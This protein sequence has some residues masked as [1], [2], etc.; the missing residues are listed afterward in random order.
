MKCFPA[1]LTLR[2]CPLFSAK[3]PTIIPEA[4]EKDKGGA[5]AEEPVFPDNKILLSPSESPTS[6]HCHYF[7]LSKVS[8]ATCHRTASEFYPLIPEL[9]IKLCFPHYLVFS[10]FLLGIITAN[11]KKGSGRWWKRYKIWSQTRS[12]TEILAQSLTS[13]SLLWAAN[14][15]STIIW[16]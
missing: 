3:F 16:G 10:V 7:W 11:K 9:R 5:G 13:T 14:I 15:S 8:F 4:C 1:A 6:F 12:W 2:M